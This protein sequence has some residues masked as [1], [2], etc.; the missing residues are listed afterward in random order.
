MDKP[1]IDVIWVSVCAAF[2]FLMQAGFMC[3]ESGL[4]RSKNSINVAAKNITDLGVSVFLFWAFGFALMFGSSVG[5][6]VGTTHFLAPAG[7]GGAWFAAVF[8]FQ[9]MF[10]STATTI[11]SGAVAE[12]MRFAGYVIVAILLSGFIYPLFGHWAWGGL[13]TGSSGWL[14]R[15]GFV[16]FAGSTVVHSVGGWVG[17]AVILMIGARNGR[18]PKGKPP[19]KI[20]GHNLVMAILGALLLWFGWFGFNGGSMLKMDEAVPGIL[21]NTMMSGV[22]GLVTGLLVSWVLDR[23]PEVPR[24]INGSLAG[25]V[26]ITANCHAVT[27]TSAVLIGAIGAVIALCLELLLERLRIDDVVGAFPVHAGAGMWG[28]VAVGLFGDLAILD[29]GLG[30]SQQ[31]GVQLLGVGVCFLWAFVFV[32]LV[33]RL[34]NR[35]FPFRVTPEVEQIGLNIAEHGATTEILDLF[36][37][38]DRQ[39][40]S[41]DMSIRVA[42]EPFTEVGQIAQRY[43]MVMESLEESTEQLTLAHSRMKNDLD[44]P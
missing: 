2:V 16:D 21:V 29:T 3:L 8:L 1:L 11:F 35:W 18:F 17:L 20:H 41:G 38:M 39:A 15:M 14:E 33:L 7:S 5:G 24:I 6:L 19:Q 34:V 26:A 43:N 25:L 22:A 36:R 42:V 4:T 10:C 31:I 13:L 23:R 28:T 12:R 37:A 30:R 9:A 44:Q 27:S 32:S 40:R